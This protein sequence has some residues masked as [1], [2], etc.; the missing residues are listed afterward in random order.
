MDHLRDGIG[1]RGY[2][3]VDPLIAYQKEG[4]GL[5]EEMYSVMEKE[6]LSRVFKIEPVSDEEELQRR[7]GALGRYRAGARPGRTAQITPEGQEN[8]SDAPP[9]LAPSRRQTPKVGRNQ[10]CP[11]GSGKKYKFCCGKDQ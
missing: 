8:R 3:G 6:V 10:P 5:F 9:K 7:R 2:A 1:L 4:F 11:C